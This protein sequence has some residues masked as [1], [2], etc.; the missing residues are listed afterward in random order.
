MLP[1]RYLC[2]LIAGAA[3]S[4]GLL[5][6]ASD[7][8]TPAVAVMA[9]DPHV[10]A[11]F[12]QPES[13]QAHAF[14]AEAYH[15]GLR[16]PGGAYAEC[17]PPA[18]VVYRQVYWRSTEGWWTRGPVRRVVSWPFRKILGRARCR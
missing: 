13:R 3:V 4:L 16:L 15:D 11:V 14:A 2:S 1:M 8:T 6:V 18:A 12:D 9:E 10:F 5:V 17:P 7:L